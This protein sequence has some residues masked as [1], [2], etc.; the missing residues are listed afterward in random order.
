ML[1]LEVLQDIIELLEADVHVL[2][3]GE[4]ESSGLYPGWDS[5]FEVLTDSG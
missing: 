2:K 1:R 5:L 3:G 4:T